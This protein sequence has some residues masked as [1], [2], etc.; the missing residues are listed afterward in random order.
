MPPVL[1]DRGSHPQRLL[2]W[3]YAAGERM[4]KP[5]LGFHAFRRFRTTH[6]SKHRLPEDLIKYW[7]GHAPE[8]VTDRYSKLKDD[9]QFRQE[10]A[11]LVGLGF[12]LDASA[13]SRG[14]NRDIKKQEMF[15]SVLKF[16]PTERLQVV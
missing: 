9:V 13:T 8:T 10:T 5:P 4:N 1:S 16:Q 12:Q 14:E 11:E 2:A 15:S 3:Q 6:L 7:L